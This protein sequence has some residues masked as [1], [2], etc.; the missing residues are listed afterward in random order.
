MSIVKVYP[1]EVADNIS[2][3][4]ELNNSIAF[5]C[6]I[7]PSDKTVVPEEKELVILMNTVTPIQI[8]DALSMKMFMLA[9]KRIALFMKG[10]QHM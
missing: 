2:D 3:L 10:C 9:G 8:A 4:V 7:L 6:E 5:D 1:S